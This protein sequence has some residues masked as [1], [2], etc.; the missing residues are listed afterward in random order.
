MQTKNTELTVQPAEFWMIWTKRGHKPRFIHDTKEGAR[1]EAERLARTNPG[2]KFIV[3]QAT[4]KFI[5][6]R[7]AEA[8]TETGGLG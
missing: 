6:E 2:V 4:E 5:M 8:A 3:L 1:I 7:P